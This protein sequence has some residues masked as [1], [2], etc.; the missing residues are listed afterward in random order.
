MK[1]PNI[2]LIYT[3]QQRWD[4][5]KAAGFNYMHTPNLDKIAQGAIFKQAYCNNPVCMPSRHSMLSGLYP[6]QIGTTCNG[7]EFPQDEM[8]AA[9]YLKPYGYVTANIGKLHFKNH[10]HRD[11]RDPH[12]DFGFDRYIISDEPGCYDD[13]YIKWVET[14]DPS[15]VPLCRSATPPAWRGPVIDGP[16][17]ETHQPYDFQGKSDLTHSAFV[18]EETISFLS[19]SKDQ[20]QPFFCISGFYAPHT[21]VNPPKEFLDYYQNSEIPEPE[22]VEGENALGLSKDEWLRVRKY[23]YALVS[24]VDH[25]VGR[26]LNYLKEEGLWDNTVIIF[27][28]DH[29]EHLGD[30]GK[31]QKGPPGLDSCVR[32]PLLFHYGSHFDSVCRDTFVEAVDILPTLLDLAGVQIPSYLP[33]KSLLPLMV[34]GQEHNRDSIYIE[35]REPG[36]QNWKTVRNSQFKY[37]RS[38]ADEELLYDLTKDPFELRPLVYEEYPEA[39]HKMRQLMI[40]R[41]F[42][43]DTM[44]LKRIGEY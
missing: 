30:H 29:G 10:A 32:V 40:A 2:L 3:D 31:I 34:E 22:W 25:E 16:P 24:H 20:K 28:S 14:K 23:Y 9:R 12:P 27:T 18:A 7:I 37:C 19:A 36:G 8:H 4:T 13:P 43:L 42:A 17:R 6:S 5:I 44:P 1:R 11:H 15:Q 33:G 41:L 35:Y 26:I 38:G 21:P 39:F